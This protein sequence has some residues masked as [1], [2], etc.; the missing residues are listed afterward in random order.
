MMRERSVLYTLMLPLLPLLLLFWYLLYYV[1][2][3]TLNLLQLLCIA[4]A[5]VVPTGSVYSAA[6]DIGSANPHY[7]TTTIAAYSW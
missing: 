6:L 7:C 3:A 2:Y 4:V 5:L 1:I